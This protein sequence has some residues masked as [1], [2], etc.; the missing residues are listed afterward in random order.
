MSK[1]DSFLKLAGER[2]SCRDFNKHPVSPGKLAKILEA[3]RLAPSARNMQ[4]VRV[5]ALTSPDA[6]AR[7]R[8]IHTMFDAPVVVMVGAKAEESCTRACDGKNWAETDATIAGTHIMLA[9]ADLGLGCTWVGSF[10]PIKVRE[11]FPETEGYVIYALFAIGH[12]SAR[13]CPSERH[14]I[15][16]SME[17]FATEL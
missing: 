16:K 10:D 15:R 7:I 6:L 14:S 1:A 2:F 4:P 5:W 3:A 12:P 8:P 13:A 9:A 17:E 11:A